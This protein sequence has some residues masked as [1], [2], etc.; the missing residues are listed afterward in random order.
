MVDVWF[1]Y[2]L[3][4]SYGTYVDATPTSV[5]SIDGM[6]ECSAEITGLTPFRTYHF[7]ICGS[8]SGGTVHGGDS[9]FE[10]IPGFY[11][12][13]ITNTATNI[14]TTFAMFQGYV[15][16]MGQSTAVEF[17]YGTD[18]NYGMTVQA[19][20]SPVTG[21]SLTEVF[22]MLG[23]LTPN[24]TYHYRVKAT[25]TNGTSYGLD[26]TFDTPESDCNAIFPANG[27]TN[28]P[29]LVTVSWDYAGI[30]MV[31]GFNVFC[32]GSQLGESIDYLGEM[33]YNCAL[34]QA[35][36][37][38]TVS[39]YV[40]PFGPGEDYPALGTQTY[41]VMSEPA[42]PT[43]VPS[44]IVF[45]QEV[46]TGGT[47]PDQ[48]VFPIIDL[49][50]GP[51]NPAIDYSFVSEPAAFTLWGMITDQP[52]LA[53]PYPEDVIG[54]F[55][56][57][58]PSDVTTNLTYYWGG[59][60]TPSSVFQHDDGS[61]T[62]TEYEY[63]GEF[64]PGSVSITA[65]P[66]GRAYTREYVIL[67]SETLPVE[68]SSFAAA[69]T[70][71][72]FASIQWTTAS[73]SDMLGYNI[74]RNTI[75]DVDSAIRINA[76]PIA[77]QNSS[78]GSSYELIDNEVS[79]NNTYY[80]WLE[81]TD[82]SGMVQLYGPVTLT[83]T[84]SGEEQDVPD[85]VLVTGIRSIYPNPF[86]PSTAISYYLVN[87]VAVELDIYNIRGEKVRGYVRGIQAGGIEHKIVWDGC[88]QDGK[89]ASSGTYLFRLTAGDK[90]YTGKALMIK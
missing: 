42:D 1:E 31:F 19:D 70:Q 37:G 8:Y 80:Y 86:N 51:W 85:A 71:S 32:N 3:D 59:S 26:M 34:P 14:F 11:P 43:G 63:I 65:N 57:G 27:E 18:L 12:I 21:S 33:V 75:S 90:E 87:D 45:A 9:T 44:A 77:A 76:E 36:W 64:V 66:G 73:E 74:L 47:G 30:D 28:M 67:S 25:N 82:L 50:D 61:N 62:W 56:V 29:R 4:M 46:I 10:T 49:G 55:T 39:W 54:A 72:G 38:E 35:G 60:E 5:Y 20:Q 68:L 81:S 23:G 2:G 15:N 22:H 6:H 83:V 53:V 78:S 69:Q 58:L 89:Q 52:Q 13:A 24:T 17:E 88:D 79:L 48:L 40:V 16:A 7:R 41:T 84:G